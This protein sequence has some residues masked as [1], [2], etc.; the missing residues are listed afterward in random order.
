M[1][2][3]DIA[4]LMDQLK[5]LNNNLLTIIEINQQLMA[6]LIDQTSEQD[7]PEEDS[8]IYLDGSRR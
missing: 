6:M 3:T 4:E 8:A 5:Q 1:A 7:E 2:D